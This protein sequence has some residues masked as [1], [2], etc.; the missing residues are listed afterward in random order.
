MT[1][2]L[3]LGD[4]LEILTTL[5]DGG[6]DAVITDPPYGVK[7]KFGDCKFGRR[8]ARVVHHNAPIYGDDKPFDPSPFLDYPVVIFS[9]ANNFASRLPDSRGWIYWDKRPG[10]K[11]NDFGDG[12][13]IW[14]NQ[15]KVI[16][17]FIHTWNG[18]MRQSQNGD[19]HFHPTEKPIALM[20][21]LITE[22][23]NE[24][25]T[26]LDPFM[27]SGT[28]GVA[29]VQTGRNFIGIE[30]EPKYY[31]IAEKRIAEA[32]LQIRMDI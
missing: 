2:E 8:G 5:A 10:M 20:T 6:V 24:G 21:Y 30:I 27:G 1:I 22:Y 11:R 14:T 19:K 25:D 31:E 13:L 29:C 18:V 28:T 15:D 9:G 4:C 32:Q 26:I 17:K 3:Y 12:E 7:V 23:T 16:R